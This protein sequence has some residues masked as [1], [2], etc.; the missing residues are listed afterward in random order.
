[1][2]RP[3]A[4]SLAYDG[5]SLEG[6]LLSPL[7]VAL[8]AGHGCALGAGVVGVVTVLCIEFVCQRYLNLTPSDL[9]VRPDGALFDGSTPVLSDCEEPNYTG[10][11]LYRDPHS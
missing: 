9:G 11:R 6:V 2:K 5:S 7:W 3:A 4:L 1:K 10:W 8:I